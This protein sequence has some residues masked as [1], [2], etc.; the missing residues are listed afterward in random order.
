MEVDMTSDDLW[1]GFPKTLAEFDERFPDEAACRSYLIELRWGGRVRCARCECDETW[2][3]RNGRFECKKCGHQTSVTAGTLLHRTRKPLR[4]WFRAMWEMAARKGGINAC[5]LQ[6]LMGFGSYGTAWN[7]LHKL[8]RA[9]AGRSCSRLDGFVV[10]DE[11]YLGGKGEVRG[12]GTS[13][14][15]VLVAAE[16]NGGRIRIEPAEDASANSIGPF[17]KR[18]ICADA[19]VTTDGWSGYSPD[20]IDGRQHT[21]EA[22][23]ED[24]SRDPFHMCH[25][26]AA[27]LKRWWLGTYH[28][29]MSPKHLAFYFEEFAFR[30]NRR[31]TQGIGRI[32]SRLLEMA[33]TSEPITEVELLAQPIAA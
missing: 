11:S 17:I 4:I 15:L 12:R 9:M 25:L 3:L 28:G 1:Q 20:A 23:A 22:R 7:W 19:F 8:R 29:S 10:I 30:F 16:E 31:K 32:T 26:V 33:I 14:A 5:E 6:R 18:N 27:L 13:K 24:A 2:E 21:T